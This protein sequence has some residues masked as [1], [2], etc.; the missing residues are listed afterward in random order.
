MIIILKKHT[1]IKPKV[2]IQ[3]ID[4][5][6][7]FDDLEKEFSSIASEVNSNRTYGEHIAMEDFA[8]YTKIQID[9]KNYDEMQRCFQFQEIRI[10]NLNDGLLNAL[11]V[12][13]CE[14]L[15]LGHV[16]SEMKILKNKL[17]PKLKKVYDSYEYH[18]F[19]LGKI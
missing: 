13:Y 10:D 2:T 5:K 11:V 18:Y 15:L 3:K 4:N 17:P 1:I 7:Y 14:S 19:N 8:M 12:S 16:S 9:N 6:E